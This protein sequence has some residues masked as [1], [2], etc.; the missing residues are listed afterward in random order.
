M[1]I[2]IKGKL[3]SRETIGTESAE[4]LSVS[5]LEEAVIEIQN[6]PPSNPP[7]GSIMLQAFRRDVLLKEGKKYWMDNYLGTFYVGN[8]EP[9]KE[10]K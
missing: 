6:L 2:R 4:D 7:A 8:L 10:R 5:P 3:I 1:K 9:E